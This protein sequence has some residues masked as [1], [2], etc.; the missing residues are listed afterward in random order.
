M[1]TKWKRKTNEH[2][3]PKNFYMCYTYS[4]PLSTRS[5]A[6][7]LNG[8]MAGMVN[9][10]LP[11]TY[12]LRFFIA[13]PYVYECFGVVYG[14][15]LYV[16]EFICW[17]MF[18]IPHTFYAIHSVACMHT[19]KIARTN[20][21][22]EPQAVRGTKV[23]TFV[24]WKNTTNLEKSRMLARVVQNGKP[25]TKSVRNTKFQMIYTTFFR[26]KSVTRRIFFEIGC[27]DRQNLWC[28]L[29]LD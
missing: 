22:S 12:K 9:F 7:W 18:V 17:A 28:I 15:R 27:A 10:L 23:K 29:F 11:R 1:R 3:Q 6:G 24:C 19:P 20:L 14:L 21:W 13:S 5:M 8:W 25:R 2:E 16:D 4:S 26:P